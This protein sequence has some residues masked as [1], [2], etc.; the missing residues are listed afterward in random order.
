MRLVVAVV[1]S[2]AC[3]LAAASC[4]REPTSDG[5][6]GS[7]GGASPAGSGAAGSA[8]SAAPGGSS[9]G[10]GA[11][12]SG[13]GADTAGSGAS[14]ATAGSGASGA[15]AGSGA[16][17]SPPAAKPTSVVEQ[18][19]QWAPPG[20]RVVPVELAVNGI[21]LF[22]VADRSA[23]ADD[24]NAGVLVGVVGGL[25]GP[26]VEGSEL[27]R[28]AIE[29]KPDPRTLAQVA[30]RVARRDAEL[31]TAPAND[32]QRKAKVRPPRFAGK[33]LVFWVWTRGVPRLLELGTLDRTT[34]ALEIAT[35]PALRAGAIDSVMRALGDTDA[36]I[37][38]GAIRLLVAACGEPKIKAALISTLS[39]HPRAQTRSAVADAIHKCGPPVIQ[40]LIHAMEHDKALQN[41]A[42]AA[43]ALGRIGDG[44]ARPALAKAA[45]SEDANL[46]WAAKKALEKLK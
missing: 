8:G 29:R 13:A 7:T 6:A 30:L 33:A 24:P 25:G 18:V 10:S 21:A 32:E 42:S 45:K 39:N 26:I 27:V 14:G 31:L 11:A 43:S 38:T 19:Q 20:S 22:A 40:P 28:R 9:A 15:A 4:S 5:R 35:P 23:A 34:G 37:D 12:G 17:A 16:S 2:A 41:R 3:V 44:R 46:A 36:T 1:A